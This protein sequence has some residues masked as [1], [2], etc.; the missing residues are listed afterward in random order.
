M[1]STTMYAAPR[2]GSFELIAGFPNAWGSAAFIFNQLC[3]H[4]FGD[5]RLWEQ[6]KGQQK[7]WGL[8]KDPRL[9]NFE[10][11]VLVSTFDHILVDRPNFNVMAMAFRLF[12]GRYP[13]N[14]QVCHLLGQAEIFEALALGNSIA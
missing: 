13:P 5:R 8:A 4:Y 12:V 9:Q 2:D 6:E 3:E 10:K 14:G 11:E 7:L 1:S